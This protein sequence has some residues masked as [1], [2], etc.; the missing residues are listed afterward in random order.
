[1]TVATIVSLPTRLTRP[2]YP[3]TETTT[4][5]SRDIR[6]RWPRRRRQ[7]PVGR[8]RL[9]N[10]L[11]EAHASGVP[12]EAIGASETTMPAGLDV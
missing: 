7:T 2:T 5:G 11:D 1:M 9:G 3:S 8:A 12:G 6:K 4:A 10:V